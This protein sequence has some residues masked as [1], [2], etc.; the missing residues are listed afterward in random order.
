MRKLNCPLIGRA[1]VGRIMCLLG[2]ACAFLCLPSLPSFP[3]KRASFLWEVY[4][5]LW[6]LDSLLKSRDIILPTKACIVKAMVFPV[7]WELSHKEGWA[8][9]NWCFRIVVLEKILEHL[10][11][12][13]EIKP[14]NLK[15]NQPWLFI[16]RTDAE[17]EAPILWPPHAKSLLIGRDP[18]ARKG[19][20]QKE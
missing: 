3:G 17:A 11:Y 1:F 20:R 16:G 18:D 15:G 13:Q 10:S 14:V 2:T 12:C 8:P 6:L 19:I 7:I 5:K 4:E 9:K